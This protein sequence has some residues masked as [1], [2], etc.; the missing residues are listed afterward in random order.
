MSDT[1]YAAELEDETILVFG[2]APAEDLQAVV[3]SL[4]T[5]P[6]PPAERAEPTKSTGPTSTGPA[7]PAN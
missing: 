4:T 5:A 2:S 6:G 1:A 7:E 3:D